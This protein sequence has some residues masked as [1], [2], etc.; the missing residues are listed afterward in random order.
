M[1]AAVLRCAVGGADGGGGLWWSEPM[2]E[3]VCMNM[4]A[5]H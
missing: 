1:Q 3:A 4:W 2:A 5:P